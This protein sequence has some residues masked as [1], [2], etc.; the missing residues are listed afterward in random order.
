MD[1]ARA[2]SFA[3]R[4][5]LASGGRMGPAG[6][7]AER[8][9]GREPAAHYGRQS[10]SGADPVLQAGLLAQLECDQTDCGAGLYQS[11]LVFGRGGCL[12]GCRAATCRNAAR[13]ISARITSGWSCP[14]AGYGFAPAILMLCSSRVRVSKV[15]ANQIV[16]PAVLTLELVY[17]WSPVT[18]AGPVLATVYNGAITSCR[19]LGFRLHG[20]FTACETEVGF[21]LFPKGFSQGADKCA[22]K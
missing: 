14:G 12:G 5:A 15:S 18:R 1:H 7:M 21:G 10:R 11:G 9:S 6:A 20:G 4:C 17:L 13:T 19:A 16:R 8:L 2:A 22:N 3:A